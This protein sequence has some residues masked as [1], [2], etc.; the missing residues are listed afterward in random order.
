MI[1][2][3]FQLIRSIKTS[4]LMK[5]TDDFNYSFVYAFRKNK[6]LKTS[7]II[8]VNSTLD[9]SLYQNVA[10]IHSFNRL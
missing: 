8:N 7:S 9:F 5:I 6:P 2:L 4:W 3:I 1:S 10:I